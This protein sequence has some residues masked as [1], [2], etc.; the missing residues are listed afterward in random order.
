M[1][2]RTAACVPNSKFGTA[3]RF[4][5]LGISRWMI[6]RRLPAKAG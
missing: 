1:E 3:S 5:R 6:Y 2:R 4:E